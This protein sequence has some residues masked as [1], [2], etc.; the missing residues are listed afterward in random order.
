MEEAK[1]DAKSG[2]LDVIT[3][4]YSMM[5]KVVVDVRHICILNENRTTHSQ[6]VFLVV[7]NDNG[8]SILRK[9]DW[10]EQMIGSKKRKRNESPLK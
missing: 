5:I 4:L 3:H 9:K 10:R 2:G 6:S 1:E 7:E 8:H